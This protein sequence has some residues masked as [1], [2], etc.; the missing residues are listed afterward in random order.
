MEK[1]SKTSYFKGFKIDNIA[2]LPKKYIVELIYVFHA[3]K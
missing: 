2:Y 3:N 1:L